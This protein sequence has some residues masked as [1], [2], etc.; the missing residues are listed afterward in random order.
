MILQQP[1]MIPCQNEWKRWEQMEYLAGKMIHA[2]RRMIRPWKQGGGRVE[3]RGGGCGRMEEEEGGEGQ[4]GGG[5]EGGEKSGRQRWISA[6]ALT[7]ECRGTGHG[8]NSH[9]PLVSTETLTNGVTALHIHG[10]THVLGSAAALA[11]HG[12]GI[13]CWKCIIKESKSKCPRKSNRSS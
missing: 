4:C 1:N 10:K 7:R 5:E 12:R 8:R 9:E 2:R 3:E 13:E 11:P 6:A